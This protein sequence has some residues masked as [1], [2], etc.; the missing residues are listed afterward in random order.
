MNNLKQ[1]EKSSTDQTKQFSAD[2]KITIGKINSILVR[3]EPCFGSVSYLSDQQIPDQST[4][5]N[6]YLTPDNPYLNTHIALSTHR[7]LSSNS[8]KSVE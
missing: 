4:V 5:F 1:I 3:I 7:L 2:N 6:Y 8:V